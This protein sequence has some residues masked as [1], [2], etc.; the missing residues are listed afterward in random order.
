MRWV[1]G[2]GLHHA[3]FELDSQRF[4]DLVL[5]PKDDIFELGAAVRDFYF[6]FFF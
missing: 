4:A 1:V 5:N 6:L 2:L 3:V